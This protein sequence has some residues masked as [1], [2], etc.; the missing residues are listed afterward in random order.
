MAESGQERTEDA[1][2]KRKQDA[3]KKGQVVRSTDLPPAVGLLAGVLVL[4][5]TAPAAWGDFAGVLRNGLTTIARPDLSARDAVGLVSQSMMGGLLAIVPVLGALLVG[6]VATGLLQTGFVVST[7]AIMPDFGK[8]NPL[9]GMKRLFS[10]KTGFELLK[11]VLRLVIFIAVTIG[12]AQSVMAQIMALGMTG[13]GGV[14]GILGDAIYALLLRV[15][16]AGAVLA[17]LDYGFQRWQFNKS[18]KMTKQEIRDEMRQTEGDPQIKSRIRRLQRERARKR[19]MS[20]V[21]KSTVVIANPTHFAIALRY[22]SGKTRAP[23]VVAKG[24][25]L[26]AQQ[27]KA[28]AAQHG[29]PI[30]EN[31]PLARTL[32]ASVAVGREIPYHL[33]RAVAEVL[34]FI[35][36][37]K[38]RW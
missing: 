13:I 20:E 10:P 33:Y 26:I 7:K 38:R 15:A 24:K 9:S 5:M 25:D 35:Y 32:Y 8:V 18:L 19:M 30:V 11:M 21:P 28:V 12:V 29:V 27:I 16:M 2:P 14:A 17:A 3:R 1:T 4:R 22:E 6:G 31:P 36:R 37:L 34:A 23:I